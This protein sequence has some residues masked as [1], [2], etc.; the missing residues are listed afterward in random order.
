MKNNNSSNKQNNAKASVKAIT[1]RLPKAEYDQLKNL[2]DKAH[3]SLN[4][5]IVW[6]L[7]GKLDDYI[8]T[9]RYVDKSQ[10]DKIKAAL[11]ELCEINNK[12][13][14]NLNRIGVNYNREIMLK[15]A[16]K[17]YRD[18]TMSR[19]AD[20]NEW[21]AAKQEYETLQKS[22]TDTCLDKNELNKL[23]EQYERV[24]KEMGEKL[25]RIVM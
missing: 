15:N 22:S 7:V 14:D 21:S 18:L 4:Q 17:K 5:I 23:F 3:K 24:N 16:E 19:C 6:T 11:E 13:L 12:I 1:I 25:W 2:A 10:A 9:I 8:G 20:V